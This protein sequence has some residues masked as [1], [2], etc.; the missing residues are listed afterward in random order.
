MT[1]DA[2]EGLAAA[3]AAVLAMTGTAVAGLLLLDA[4]RAGELGPLTAAGVALAFGVAADVHA[5][6]AGRLPVAVRGTVDV[7]PLGVS[8]AGAV[9]LGV[10]LVRRG[11]RGL[12]VRSVVAVVAVP[13]SAAVTAR[14]AR[15]T[16]ALHLPRRPEAL[17][18]GFS[19]AAGPAVA[20]AAAWVLTVVAVCWLAVR[21]PAVAAA[22][23]GLL[24]ALGGLTV[25]CLL[26]AWVIGGAMAAGAVVLALP[27]AVCGALV[28]GFGVPWTVRSD[29]I[30][31]R[32]LDTAAP[33]P[34]RVLMMVVAGAALL[35]CAFVA[36]LR[37]GRPGG[38]WR[39]ATG[40]AV[41]LAPVVAAVLVAV[42]LLGRMS[43]R[44]GADA[45]GFS[46][47]LLDAQLAANPLHAGGAGLVGGAVAGLVA[48]LLA[49]AALLSWPACNDRVG[50]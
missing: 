11:S 7:M 21:F 24:W 9:V 8:L 42:S 49:D 34:P 38:P 15:G 32:V 26:A 3:A 6:G 43:V 45:Y 20:A 50:R 36:A 29:G 41:R 4:G 25:V 13:A 14:L 39:R 47:P 46:L 31:S 48:S 33:V 23:R 22:L 2:L 10:L 30:L 18:A 1:R 19:V 28:L 27:L 12:P 17:E 35:A 16:V 40:L 5:A 44:L 37:T